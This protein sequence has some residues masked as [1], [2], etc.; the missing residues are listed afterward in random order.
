MLYTIFWLPSLAAVCVADIRRQRGSKP[1][2]P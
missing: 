2:D 1:N